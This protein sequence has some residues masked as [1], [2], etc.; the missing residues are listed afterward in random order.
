ME[1]RSSNWFPYSFGVK[2]L[3]D[4]EEKKS[5]ETRDLSKIPQ[6]QKSKSSAPSPRPSNCQEIYPEDRLA[7]DLG[8]DSLSIAELLIWLD[9]EFEVSDVEVS[10]VKTLADVILLLGKTTVKTEEP[11]LSEQW[12]DSNRPL[13]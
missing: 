4:I 2:D 10:E 12:I 11:P 3:P 9:E 13:T 7:D 1:K 5:D 8:M 6:E